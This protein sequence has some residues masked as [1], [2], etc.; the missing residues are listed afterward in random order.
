MD[1]AAHLPPKPDPQTGEPRPPSAPLEPGNTKAGDRREAA[2]HKVKP[3]PPGEGPILEWFYP[4]RTSRV[5][6]G[7]IVSVLGLL[8]YVTKDWI[9][10][11]SGLSWV[12]TWWLWLLLTP[13]PFI[14]LL[15]GNEPVSA[16]AD[17]LAGRR[18]FVKTYD[19]V[20][21]KVGI[22][23]G[24]AAH[25]LQIADK[26]GKTARYRIIELQ[27]NHK[28]WDLVYNGLI[29]SVHINGAETN[30]RARDYLLLE[31]PP[32]VQDI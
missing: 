1:I 2:R 21:V 11:E 32:T 6:A 30:Q 8:V 28:L 18:I 17:W 3:P 19:L 27:Q 9:S 24:G 15:L 5:V 13:W 4:N 20:K 12:G 29:H 7:L 23:S 22:T 26:H 10:G 14:F 25:E 16:G 31:Y